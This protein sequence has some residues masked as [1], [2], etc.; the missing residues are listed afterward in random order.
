MSVP[1]IGFCL[2]CVGM[3]AIYLDWHKLGGAFQSKGWQFRSIA[4]L[5]EFAEMTEF[6]M[7]NSEEVLQ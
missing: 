2:F 6:R 5:D 4:N 3:F 1:V 7:R